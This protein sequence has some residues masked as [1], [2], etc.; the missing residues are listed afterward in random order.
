[1]EDGEKI[2][3]KNDRLIEEKSHVDYEDEKTTAVHSH[4]NLHVFWA[5]FFMIF[6]LDNVMSHHHADEDEDKSSKSGSSDSDNSIF[7]SEAEKIELVNLDN[8]KLNSPPRHHK[9]PK[10]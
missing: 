3:K 7:G 6:F 9:T 5:T 1:M 2:K 4:F 10:L 8:F